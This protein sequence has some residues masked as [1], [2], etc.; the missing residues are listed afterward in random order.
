MTNTQRAI[1]WTGYDFNQDA[2]NRDPNKSAKYAL[3]DIVTRLRAQGIADPTDHTQAEAYAK[4]YLAPEYQKL[5]YTVSG[6]DRDKFTIG[7]R[8]N[9]GGELIDWL[10]NAGGS[11]PEFG[12]QSHHQGQSAN[13]GAGGSG[14]KM[15]TTQVYNNTRQSIGGVPQGYAQGGAAQADPLERLL[16]MFF[17][18]EMI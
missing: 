6:I 8:E 4:Q 16:Q 14:W 11:N 15:P 7:T 1:G 18:Q 10:V 2:K 13:P 9:P 12:W 5:G 17:Q 3:N